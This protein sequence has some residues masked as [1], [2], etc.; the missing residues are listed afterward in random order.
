MIEQGKPVDVF[1]SRRDT[2][3]QAL[4]DGIVPAAQS[5]RIVMRQCWTN[6]KE[7]SQKNWLLHIRQYWSML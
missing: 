4:I 5:K 2:R 1:N 3:T 6:L 7:F